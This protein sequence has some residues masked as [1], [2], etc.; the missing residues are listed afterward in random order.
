[1]VA[2]KDSREEC[3]TYEICS[4]W[5][6]TCRNTGLILHRWGQ[7]EQL[8]WQHRGWQTFESPP[9]AVCLLWCSHYCTL[10]ALWSI[11]GWCLLCFVAAYHTGVVPCY[12]HVHGTGT[13]PTPTL[14]ACI[15]SLIKKINI[16]STLFPS[17]ISL[18][19][20]THYP[21]FFSFLPSLGNLFPLRRQEAVCGHAGKTADGHRREKDVW[22]VW[23]H[24][25]VHGAPRA[26]RYK[27]R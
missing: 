12:M 20:S 14:T 21:V 24:R 17:V 7:T 13:T 2:L 6:K 4:E 10:V 16:C 5:A 25:G 11:A 15:T 18:T 26:G 9:D 8:L 3:N 23:Q 1:M 27:Q 19:L 22:A